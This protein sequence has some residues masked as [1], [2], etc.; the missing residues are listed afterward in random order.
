MNE[1]DKNK[2]GQSDN[3]NKNIHSGSGNFGNRSNNFGKKESHTKLRSII[4]H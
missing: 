4:K 3:Q 2:T 1:Q